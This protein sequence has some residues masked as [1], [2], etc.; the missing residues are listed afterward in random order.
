MKNA[1]IQN[2]RPIRNTGTTRQASLQTCRYNTSGTHI[3]ET[4]LVQLAKRPLTNQKEPG[5]C[6]REIHLS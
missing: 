4:G 6:D 3:L 1:W 5:W 2:K